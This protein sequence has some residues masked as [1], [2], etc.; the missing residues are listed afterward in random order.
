M[1]ATPIILAAVNSKV[2]LSCALGI[3]LITLAFAHKPF[4]IMC[5]LLVRKS[6]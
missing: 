1:L 5:T 4:E 3:V 6:P 2:Y